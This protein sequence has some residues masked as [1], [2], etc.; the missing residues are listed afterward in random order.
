MKKCCMKGVNTGEKDY[1]ALISRSSNRA[2]T[3]FIRRALHR[4]RADRAADAPTK[5]QAPL[6]GGD[7]ITSDEFRLSVGG[8][9]VE[10]TL[11]PTVPIPQQAGSQTGGGGIPRQEIRAGAY[12]LIAMARRSNLQQAAEAAKSLDPRRSPTRCIPA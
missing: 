8:P 1:S 10:G 12:T 11:I 6:M 2:P 7:G 3:S 4:R 5:G 9:G